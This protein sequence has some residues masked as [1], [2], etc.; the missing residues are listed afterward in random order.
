[1][2]EVEK[3]ESITLEHQ[4]D[5]HFAKASYNVE[6]KQVSAGV[7]Y[8]FSDNATISLQVTN[9]NVQGTILH[10]GDTHIL[11]IDV[12]SD[13]SYSGVFEDSL[14]KVK[15]NLAGGKA[16]LMEGKIPEG[17]IEI[18]GDHH[19]IKI[20]VD[21]NGN[22]TGFIESQ[23][24]KYGTFKIGVDRGNIFGSFSHKG[25]NHE[26]DL[27]VTQDGNWKASVSTGTSA[28]KFAFSVAK[29]MFYDFYLL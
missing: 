28:S 21:K 1:M 7:I 16:S 3:R 2:E 29:V 5:H 12:S 26:T 8:G 25:D 9:G 18:N 19:K 20:G 11:K 23:D 22:L 24:T 10:T 27:T 13:G 17:G 14:H 15:I 6:T 4:G